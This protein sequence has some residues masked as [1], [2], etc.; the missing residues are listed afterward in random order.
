[1]APLAEH[2][3]ARAASDDIQRPR[4]TLQTRRPRPRRLHTT[5]AARACRN[6]TPFLGLALKSAMPCW[7]PRL[8]AFHD[9]SS[10]AS[11]TASPPPAASAATA[12][13]SFSCGGPFFQ[14]HVSLHI[15]IY[16]ILFGPRWAPASPRAAWQCLRRRP[17]CCPSS[18]LLSSSTCPR[19]AAGAYVREA[20][21]TAKDCSPRQ[22]QQ[23]LSPMTR[24]LG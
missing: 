20:A 9:S 1:L 12:V 2:A 10:A 15:Y 7:N 24:S 14:R 11:R 17:R 13:S 3:A 23:R 21:A 5:K 6:A 19:A 8:Y 4:G 22:Q 18:A 16:V